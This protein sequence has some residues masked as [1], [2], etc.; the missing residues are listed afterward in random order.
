[1]ADAASKI[2]I[3]YNLAQGGWTETYY[4]NATAGSL[5]PTSTAWVRF[6]NQRKVMMG[7][8]AFIYGM[9]IS[10]IGAR[11][12]YSYYFG[13]KYEGGFANTTAGVKTTLTDAT[14]VDA[15]FRLSDA[16]TNKRSLW[17]RG[18][19]PGY[20]T[21]DATG[22]PIQSTNLIAASG[23]LLNAMTALGLMIRSLQAPPGGGLIS[24]PITSVAAYPTNAQW[25]ILTTTQAPGFILNT[26]QQVR[27]HG[28]P[29]DYLPGF[30]RIATVVDQSSVPPF[31]FSIP[32]RFRDSGAYNPPKMSGIKV[33]Y[34]ATAIQNLEFINYATHKT[35]RPF[36]SLRGKAR[37][38]VRAQ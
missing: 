11:A 30:P 6:F 31:S 24:L 16:S 20:V 28:I 32:Y 23:P 18:I 8:P 3:F 15:L 25:S 2:V 36:G 14:A 26:G 10:N 34:N 37:A 19:P 13:A 7:Q 9:R 17:L 35:G 12:S 38:L 27:F 4:S 33:A 29:F 21:R 1:M 5:D 22:N